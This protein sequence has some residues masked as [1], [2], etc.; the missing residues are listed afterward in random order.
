LRQL[1]QLSAW[2]WRVLLQAPWVLLL[3][4]RRLR[5]EGY[6]KTLEA[7]Q[8]RRAS[9]QGAEAQLALARDTARALAVAVR[10][11][12]WRPQCLLRS[13]S[14]GWFLGRR[15]IAFEVKIGVPGGGTAPRSPIDPDFSAHAWVEHAGV[16]LNDRPD[17]AAE[18]RAFD[19]R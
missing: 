1:G 4:W 15:G 6:R 9:T 8:P 5:S 12:P 14:L 17:I 19:A 11:G 7:V 3:T 2:Q 10:Y 16:V 18:F 13:L